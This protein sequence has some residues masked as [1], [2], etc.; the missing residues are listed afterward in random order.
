MLHGP[1]SGI[2]SSRAS[3][4]GSAGST[5]FEA[6]SRATLTI[7]TARLGDLYEAEKQWEKARLAFK[8]S[9]T[10][11]PNEPRTLFKLARVC[12]QLERYE[13]ARTAAGK[14][15]RIDPELE[16]TRGLLKGLGGMTPRTVPR[17][18]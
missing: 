5:R 18:P 11:A 6:T 1:I 15:V 7:A 10:T 8:E 16:I 4:A 14:A 12:L 3:P 17:R 2:A 13:E 9:L